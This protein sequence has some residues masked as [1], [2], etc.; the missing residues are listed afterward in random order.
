M[1]CGATGWGA[2]SYGYRW[3]YGSSCPPLCFFASFFPEG[4]GG[5]GVALC[6]GKL[7]GGSAFFEVD[8]ESGGVFLGGGVFVNFADECGGVQV[9]G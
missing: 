7:L 8:L 9:V 3:R 2:R 4:L 5:L 6:G 1:T